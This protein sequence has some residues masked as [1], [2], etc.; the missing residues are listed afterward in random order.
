MSQPTPLW[1]P[2]PQRRESSQMHQF[3]ER[4]AERYGFAR[5]WNALY[6]WSVRDRGTFWTEL[7]A[8][9]GIQFDGVVTTAVTGDD[10]LS[11]RWFPGATLN[12][13]AHMLRE[14]PRPDGAADADADA[15][16]FVNEVGRSAKLSRGQLRA[17]VA[18]AR[19]GLLRL[20]VQRGDRVAGYMPNLPETLIM[21]LAAASIGAIWSSCSPDFGVR[22]V[23]DRFGQ[24]EPTALI[25]ADGYF[26]SGKRF[27][28]RDRIRDVQAAIPSLKH[29]VVVPYLNGTA[30]I[31]G[32]TSASLWRD[33]LGPESEPAPALA[34]EP[35][36]FDHPLFIMYSSGTTGIPK[37]IVHGHGGTLLQLMKEL[38]LHTDVRP[39]ERVFYFT[40]CGWMM[41]NWLVSTLGTGAAVVLFD[42]NPA[43][44]SAHT[45]WEMAASLKVNVFGTSPKFL[46][47]CQKARITPGREHDLSALRA[48]LSTGSPLSIEQFHWVYEN[49]KADVHL[50]SIS[51]GTDIISCFMLGNPLLPVYAGEIQSRG[52][53]MAVQAWD[54]NRE[55]V[56]GQKGEL[57][58]VAP[59]PSQPVGFWNDPDRSKYRAAYFEHF[60]G[61][62]RHG[63]YIEIT[64]RGGVIVYGRSDATLNPGG[65]RIGTAEIYR[66]VEEIPEVLDSLVVSR[67]V[68]DDVEI[69]LFVVLREGVK[70][71]NGNGMK[72]RI[73]Q[74]IASAATRRH[75]P[76]HIR[77]VRAIP[78]TISGKKVELAVQKILN[79]EEVKNQDALSNPEVL[80]EYR[81]MRF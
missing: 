13:A 32:L 39:H 50:A 18:R 61:I 1:T 69:V 56:T 64:P 12:Y 6:E 49:I 52:L 48:V 44:P 11:A 2:S 55:P 75:V 67:D 8:F 70:F 5:E 59:F 10:M 35:V 20:G 47:A 60:P 63:D 76:R 37:C 58:C 66:V 71:E 73:R 41:W 26:Y 24:I 77:Q 57:V 33:F 72:E 74:A 54:D 16:L 15:I 40:T 22:G 4:C 46:S 81:A 65:I 79:G 45:L 51:G 25:A 21:M 80:D 19:A 68:G 14:V 3:L 42:G 7:A 53:G 30:D 38:M 9:A 28:I 62:W 31:S 23:L 29:T 36:P 34:F 17:E 27:D 43:H 78:Y